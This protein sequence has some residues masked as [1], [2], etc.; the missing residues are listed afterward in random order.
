MD[1]QIFGSTSLNIFACLQ[2][3]H[4][5]Y[6]HARFSWTHSKFIGSLADFDGFLN[7][8]VNSVCEKCCL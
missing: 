3:F 6:M 2:E 8:V 4:R 5:P 7:F 1:M